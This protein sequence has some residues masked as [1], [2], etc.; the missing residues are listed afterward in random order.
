MFSLLISC[1][2]KKFENLIR[3][4]KIIAFLSKSKLYCNYKLTFQAELIYGNISMVI[5]LSQS[6]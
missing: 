2:Y 6:L 3:S 5:Y 1:I 4:F